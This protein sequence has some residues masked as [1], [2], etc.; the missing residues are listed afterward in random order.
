MDATESLQ[1]FGN[2]FTVTYYN[3]VDYVDTTASYTGNTRALQSSV[4]DLPQDLMCLQY[5]A[6]VTNLNLNPSY[7]TV[8]FMPQYSILNTT[9]IHT[10]LFCYTSQSSAAVPPYQSPDWRWIING[11]EQVFSGTP[12]NGQLD[13]VQVGV[14]S[15][16][17][18]NVDYSQQSTFNAS[19]VRVSF[20]APV[21]TDAGKIYFY[22]APPYISSDATGESGIVSGTTTTSSSGTGGGVTNQDIQQTNGLLSSLINAVDGLI[23][24][25][26]SLFIP[27]EDFLEDWIEDMQDLL[28]DH[29]GGIYQAIEEI[30]DMF[31]SITGISAATSF[32]VD[33]CNIPLAGSTLTL[34]NWDVPLKTTALPQIFYDALALII[35]FLVSA[36]FLNMCKRKLEIFLIPDS[37][38][39]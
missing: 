10:A 23:D 27:D 36:A 34:G 29:L 33:A 6:P 9:Q 20:V 15:C 25:I 2:T 26:L 14:D 16:F 32:H 37:E 31:D 17:Y 24:G 3:G 5:T 30:A 19:S 13:T 21:G 8:Q 22:L 12:V 7:I 1:V 11:N 4:G 35:D 18:V 28:S 39:V 38:K